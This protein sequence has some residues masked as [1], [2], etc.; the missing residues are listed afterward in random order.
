MPEHLTQLDAGVRTAQ[1]IAPGYGCRS[2][3]FLAAALLA[4]GTDLLYITSAHRSRHLSGAAESPAHWRA[5]GLRADF[6]ADFL[7]LERPDEDAARARY[8]RHAPMSTTIL[9]FRTLAAA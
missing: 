1:V 8:P 3:E 5:A 7:L 2:N 9:A 4:A 6:G